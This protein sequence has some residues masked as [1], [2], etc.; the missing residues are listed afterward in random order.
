[1]SSRGNSGF[2]VLPVH[3]LSA[4]TVYLPCFAVYPLLRRVRIGKAGC[5]ASCHDS[6]TV[7]ASASNIGAE[8]RFLFKICGVSLL[9]RVVCSNMDWPVIDLDAGNPFFP[10]C[11]NPWEPASIAR[12]LFPVGIVQVLRPCRRSK[13]LQ[14]IVRPDAV[15]MVNVPIW[16]SAVHIEQGKPMRKVW[17]PVNT[18]APVPILAQPANN[19]IRNPVSE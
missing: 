13:V 11:S 16:P 5:K 10:A 8:F 4:Q 14:P 9:W 18:D 19:L 7:S 6:G 1:M 15:D 12:V 2:I 3:C 17:N